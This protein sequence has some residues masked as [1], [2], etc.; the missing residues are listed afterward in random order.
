MSRGRK[1]RQRDDGS[2]LPISPPPMLT[3]DL[4]REA[5]SRLRT[6]LTRIGTSRGSDLETVCIAAKRLARL[7]LLY[8]KLDIVMSADQLI[9]GATESTG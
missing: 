6:A 2:A 1:P 3:S 7:Q 8:K 9:M 5:Y 4:E